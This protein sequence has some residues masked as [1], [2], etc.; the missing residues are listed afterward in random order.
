MAPTNAKVTKQKG[1][2]PFTPIAKRTKRPGSKRL[3]TTKNQSSDE[4]ASMA[5]HQDFSQKLDALLK[6]VTALSTCDSL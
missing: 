1:V 5:G 4:Q 3:V 6:V 2:S